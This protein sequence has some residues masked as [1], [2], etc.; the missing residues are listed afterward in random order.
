MFW[1]EDQ[2]PGVKMGEEAQEKKVSECFQ[3]KGQGQCS[4][5]D[6]CSFSHEKQASE[7]TKDDRLLP[8]PTQRQNRLTEKMATKRK[9]L[10]REVRFCVNTKIVIIRRVS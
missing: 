3:W 1:N 5:G 8:H 4:K 10:T 7:K 6:S 2:L 9:I